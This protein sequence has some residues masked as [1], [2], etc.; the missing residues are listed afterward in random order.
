MQRLVRDSIVVTQHAFLGE[1]NYD[2]SGAIFVGIPPVTPY[3]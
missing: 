3:P 1:G 2:A